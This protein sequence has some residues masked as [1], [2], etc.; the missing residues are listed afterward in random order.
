MSNTRSQIAMDIAVSQKPNKKLSLKAKPVDAL[1][2]HTEAALN[3]TIKFRNRPEGTSPP[4]QLKKRKEDF[5][6]GIEMIIPSQKL[7]IERKASL[8][9]MGVSDR[10]STNGA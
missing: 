1:C 9:Q 2:M 10:S 7:W 3:V 4:H 6:L 8:R 5:L